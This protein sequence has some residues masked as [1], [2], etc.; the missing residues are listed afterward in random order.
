MH[1]ILRSVLGALLLAVL[2]ACST[3]VGEPEVEDAGGFAAATPRG[4]L[5]TLPAG[6]PLP[7]AELPYLDR[8]DTLETSALRGTPAVVNFWAT[9]CT[10]CVDEMPDF[11]EVHADL[12][13]QVRFI[14]VNVEDRHDKALV[15]AEETGVSYEL[16]VD[17]DRSYYFAV[18]A[19][20]MP[21][22]LFV[23]DEGRIAYR[24]AGPL[25]ADG[26]RELV[27]EHLDVDTGDVGTG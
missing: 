16:V 15:F 24:H 26:L 3:P 6:D 1:L 19:R 17:D 18:L 20:G 14:G 4:G 23:D 22:T 8:D 2:G 12:D 21:T 25:D 10:F 5:E 13:G 7:E 11:E 27:E 9:W